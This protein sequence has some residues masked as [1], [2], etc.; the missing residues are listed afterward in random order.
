MALM[1]AQIK[2]PEKELNAME[3]SNLSDAEFNALIIRMFKELS[4]DLNS[5]K[6]I[7]SE[8]KDSQIE[9]K[10]NLQGNNSTVDE[11]ENQINDMEHKEAKHNQ[12]EQQ[13]EKRIQKNEDSVSNLWDNFKHSNIHI[14]GA[15]EGEEKE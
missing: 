5:I 12:S 14:T 10:N 9:I 2:T 15:P 13:E 4:E 8:M 6:K 11:A 3:I 1:K 7:Q